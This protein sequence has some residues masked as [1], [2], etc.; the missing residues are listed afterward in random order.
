MMGEDAMSRNDFINAMWYY[1]MG[2]KSCEAFFV[3]YSAFILSDRRGDSSR[4]P[5]LACSLRVDLCN[6]FVLVWSKLA[7]SRGSRG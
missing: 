1:E 6:N 4:F 7:E 2:P 5:N 3:R